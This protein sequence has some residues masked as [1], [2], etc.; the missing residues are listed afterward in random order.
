MIGHPTFRIALLATVALSVTTSASQS[1]APN[2]ERLITAVEPE[3]IQWR[4]HLHQHPELSNREVETARYVAERLRSFGLEPQTG[5]ARTGVV[6]VL[7]GG[8]PGPVVALR[9][10]M[11][12]LPV[13][14]EVEPA[15]CQQRDVRIR[16]QQGRRDA[17]VRTRHARRDPAGDG[18][19]AVAGEGSAAGIGEVHLP[20]GRGGCADRRAAGRRRADGRPKGCCRI[21]RSTRC[22]ACTSSPTSRPARSPIA[23][24]RSWLRPISSTSSSPASRRTGPRR[25]AASIRSSSAR[26]SS[27]RCRRS[28][29][30]TSTSRGCRPSSPSASSRPVSATTSFPRPRSLVGTIRTFDDAVQ[31][32]IHARVK[33]IAEG[34]AAGAGAT[35]DVEDHQGLS[36][37]RPTI[38]RSPRGCCRRSSASRP[39]A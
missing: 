17:R 26:R 22:S 6:A 7:R 16:G 10:D 13:R 28:S 19:G 21:R 33:R 5:I 2:L 3:L 30:A 18:A 38:R 31:D 8:R 32:D 4:R 39:G 23:A 9:A 1:L 25:G 11:D 36:G 24:A 14:E 37:D 12:G 27:R 34:I 20:A 35:V 29:A 15:V